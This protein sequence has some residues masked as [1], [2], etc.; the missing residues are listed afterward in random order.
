MQA[1]AAAAVSEICEEIEASSVE[2]NVF[3][4]EETLLRIGTGVMKTAKKCMLGVYDEYRNP[5]IA[6]NA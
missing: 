4:T 5:K 3:C 6:S 2:K 1:A